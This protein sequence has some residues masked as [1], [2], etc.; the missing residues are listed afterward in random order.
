MKNKPP[1]NIIKLF[2]SIQLVNGLIGRWKSSSYKGRTPTELLDAIEK[3]NKESEK[4][5]E[6]FK[7]N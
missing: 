3:L 4:Y 2:E 6:Q 1:S 7:E 5:L